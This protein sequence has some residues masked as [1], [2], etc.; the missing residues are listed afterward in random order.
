MQQVE[1]FP[2]YEKGS[3]GPHWWYVM[4]NL[5]ATL[6]QRPS[7]KERADLKLLL[8]LLLQKIP[9]SECKEH[10]RDYVKEHPITNNVVKDPYSAFSY[11]CQFHNDVNKR[12][13]KPV[14]DCS[15]IYD[16]SLKMPQYCYDCYVQ[17][18][19]Q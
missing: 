6:P 1:R 8:R 13:G 4:Q 3:F 12:T 17:Q 10:A 7:L 16:P 19:V 15:K 5:C 11:I 18:P 9:C 14:V 2:N